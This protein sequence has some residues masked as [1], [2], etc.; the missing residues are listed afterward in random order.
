MEITSGITSK[1]QKKIPAELQQ[2]DSPILETVPAFDN[3]VRDPKT[4]VGVPT[5]EAVRDIKAFVAANK[6]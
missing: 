2:L 5:E 4:G 3:T 6:Q 1:K